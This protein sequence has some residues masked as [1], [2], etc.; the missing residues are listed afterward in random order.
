[1]SC[2]SPAVERPAQLAARIACPSTPADE[3]PD[4][5]TLLDRRDADGRPAI[6]IVERLA[7]RAPDEPLRRAGALVHVRAP[8]SRS[9]SERLVHSGRVSV[10]DAEADALSAAW[11]VVTRRPPPSRWERCDAI[12]NQA[13][14]ASRMRRQRSPEAEPLPEDFDLAALEVGWPEA[15]AEPPGGRRGRRGAHARATW[16]CSS[17][18]GSKENRSPRWPRPSAAPTT[19]CASSAGGPKPRCGVFARRYVSEGS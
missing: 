19:P 6:R 18:P 8:T 17:G 3:V 9:M 10:L 14:R 12:W 15:Q 5:L 16:S 4:L 1:M 13:R 11:E 2:G 7:T